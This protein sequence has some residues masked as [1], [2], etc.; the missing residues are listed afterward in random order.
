MSCQR[1]AEGSSNMAAALATLGM[2]TCPHMV[3]R[4]REM[5]RALREIA[6]LRLTHK[7]KIARS[8]IDQTILRLPTSIGMTLGLVTI[9]V[10]MI[11]II[12]SIVPG[13]MV[14]SRAA[15]AVVTFTTWAEATANASGS[16]A[17][18]SA[19]PPMIL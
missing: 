16:A 18:S 9:P 4:Q 3:H 2:A 1:N 14:A 10:V 13:N 11:P 17:S 19:W 15:L 6:G 12:T 8:V 5:L 7:R